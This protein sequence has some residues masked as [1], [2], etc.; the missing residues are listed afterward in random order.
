M[1][2]R[3]D[4]WL[5]GSAIALSFLGAIL[6]YSAT[7]GKLETQ[8]LDPLTFLKRHLVNM[9]LGLGLAVVIQRFDY[10]AIRAYAPVL[11]AA[12]LLGLLVVLTPIG[13]TINGSHSW[14]VLPAGFSIEPAEFAKVAV[15]LMMAMILSEKHDASETPRGSDIGL[16]LL[17]AVVP[18][19][20]ILKQPNVGTVLMILGPM[21]AILAVAGVRARVLAAVLGSGAV[22][23]AIVVQL[24]LVKTYQVQRFIAF[25]QPGVNQRT[26]GYNTT[27]ARIA[28]GSG[29]WVGEGL[30]HGTQTQGRFVPENQTDFIFSVLG[31]ELGF[32]GSMALIVL[33]GIFLWRAYRIARNADDLFGRLVATG[34][35]CWIGVQAF[36]NIGMNLGIMPVTG[37][38]LPF[39]SY[40]GSSMFAVWI[41]VGLLLNVHLRSRQ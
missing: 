12:S 37:V 38:P 26:F 39:L 5:V 2:R 4:W 41:A 33:L 28:I 25:V 30:F 1:A 19:V 6:I 34:I 24:H 8:G 35:L 7:R 18:M 21:L 13:R 11:Y 17:V 9:V 36:E 16:A 32:L 15:I 23:T 14:I 29:G 31:E 27:E 20:L 10:R 40:G 3:V 22:I